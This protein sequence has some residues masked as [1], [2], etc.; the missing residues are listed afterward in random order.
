MPITYGQFKQSAVMNIA[1]VSPGGTQFRQMTNASVERLMR[2]GDWNGSVVPIFVCVSRGCIVWPRYVKWPRYINVCN[3]SFVPIKNMWWDFIPNH[4]SGGWT[5][6]DWSTWIASGWGGPRVEVAVQPKTPLFQDILGE[7]RT[8]RAYPSTPLDNNQTVTIYGV[9]NNGQPLTTT[10]AGAWT[11]GLKVQLKLPYAEFSNQGS[12]VLV[13][14]IDRVI[15]DETQ[16]PV[17]LYAWNAASSVLEDLAYYEGSETNPDYL[18][19]QI[20]SPACGC[21]NSDGSA[22]TFGVVA[23]V[24]LQHVPVKNDDDLV[25]IDNVEA[26]KNMFM[27]I[28]SEEAVD[29]EN[30]QAYEQRALRALNLDLADRDQNTQIPV[31]MGATGRRNR[32]IGRQRTF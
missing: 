14:R 20:R 21:S 17:R 2:R 25:I 19:T 6:S 12:A 28:R 4:R 22:Q 10:G 16:G 26:M 5:D 32:G 7:G 29:F 31:N 1:G 9:D 15:K 13:R 11:P 23:L 3:R 24:K 30:S 8:V 27:A 18:K